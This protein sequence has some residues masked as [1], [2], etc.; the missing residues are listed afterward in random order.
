MRKT[1]ATILMGA[2]VAAAFVAPSA[3]AGRKKRYKRVAK[4]QYVM[5][6][7]GAGDVGGFC[8]DEVQSC[9]RFKTTKK[10]RFVQVTIKD[11]AGMPV[12][13]TISHPDQNGDGF[14][15][16]LGDFCG[17]SKK[18]AIQ[19]GAEVIVFPYMVGSAGVW[20]SFGG[21]G[22]CHSVATQGTIIGT[23]TKK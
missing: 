12:L 23:F 19:P 13:G 4:S 3:E 2:L 18:V 16:S 6:A 20:E 7:I 10:D 21:P 9:A 15:E 17:K 14:V 1:F 22:E 5:P 8:P 11:A